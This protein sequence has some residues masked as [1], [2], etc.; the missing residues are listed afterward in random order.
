MKK[1]EGNGQQT[2][3]SITDADMAKLDALT[4]E[5][6]A[7]HTERPRDDRQLQPAGQ[8]GRTPGAQHQQATQTTPQQDPERSRS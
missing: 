1:A 2:A 8:G 4:H 5:G 6:V 7:G 3:S